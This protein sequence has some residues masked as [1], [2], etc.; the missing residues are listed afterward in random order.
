MFSIQSDRCLGSHKTRFFFVSLD[1]IMLTIGYSCP[2]NMISL[3][4]FFC[5]HAVPGETLE[6]L[7]LHQHHVIQM[8]LFSFS[9][10][11]L[12]LFHCPCHVWCNLIVF[13][14]GEERLNFFHVLSGSL[15]ATITGTSMNLEVSFYCY[16]HLF[17]C[18]SLFYCTLDI[19]IT[20]N[21]C[22]CLWG[23]QLLSIIVL[24]FYR[25]ESTSNSI[26]VSF[27]CVL[28]SS[29]LVGFS[30]Q[31]TCK[32]CPIFF[33]IPII[34]LILWNEIKLMITW[35]P[36]KKHDL[37]WLLS[38]YRLFHERHL[39]FYLIW[40]VVAL[41]MAIISVDLFL[42]TKD[43]RRMNGRHLTSFFLSFFV[44][45]AGVGSQI[46]SSLSDTTVDMNLVR[47]RQVSWSWKESSGKWSQ[48][49]GNKRSCLE[50]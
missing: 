39:V 45:Q 20:F 34:N 37:H 17:A 36:S 30:I 12:V 23:K 47:D 10:S 27:H 19:T 40:L 8:I 22:T 31:E 2:T 7:C 5:N 48:F 46:T 42:E 11:L 1:I 21:L 14:E 3:L 44:R 43:R 6:I 35:C 24:F 13:R 4:F 50:M 32:R 26:Q 49:V 28:Y 25:P 18:F 29:S 15:D 41:F 16:H 33:S 38:W 9:S